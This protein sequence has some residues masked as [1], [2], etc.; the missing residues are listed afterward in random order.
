MTNFRK[1]DINCL[2]IPNVLKLCAYWMYCSG[3]HDR[4]ISEHLGCSKY[5]VCLYRKSLGLRPLATA[6]NANHVIWIAKNKHNVNHEDKPW[7]D[8]ES[9]YCDTQ[10]LKKLLNKEVLA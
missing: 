9:L 2:D 6:S 4:Y 8:P 1:N 10:F 3:Y 7:A 5:L